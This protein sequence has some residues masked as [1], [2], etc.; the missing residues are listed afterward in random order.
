MPLLHAACDGVG[1]LI[2]HSERPRAAR[3][4]APHGDCREAPCHHACRRARRGNQ[5]I[6]HGASRRRQR[7]AQVADASV[8]ETHIKH[9][10]LHSQ[11]L[12]RVDSECA[13]QARPNRSRAA[14]GHG[15]NLN[16]RR[17]WQRPA[18]RKR[19]GRANV[20]QTK[21]VAPR[22]QPAAPVALPGGIRNSDRPRRAQQDLLHIASLQGGLHL[23]QHRRRARHH[24]RRERR[25][26]TD[27]GTRRVESRAED[28]GARE[29]AR[30][31]DYT[32][33]ATGRHQQDAAAHVGVTCQH[34]LGARAA[35]DSAPRVVR[36]PALIDIAAVCAV[37]A[38][39]NG[40]QL[41]LPHIHD[42]LERCVNQRT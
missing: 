25:S 21:A 1:H 2:G 39:C 42:F 9:D 19:H 24:R 17:D 38:R 3:A 16:R 26:P 22:H 29:R 36:Q 41:A 10:A 32:A 18:C 8:R 4:L 27:I 28:A 34:A 11:W 40:L 7:E 12:P 6:G 35:H 14:D 23:Q 20:K 31:H 30:P 37:I 5:Q 13:R 33:V 15:H